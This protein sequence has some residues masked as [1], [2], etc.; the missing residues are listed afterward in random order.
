MANENEIGSTI[1]GAYVQ[2]RA[3]EPDDLEFLAMLTNDRTVSGMVVGWDFPVS[4]HGQT[5]WLEHASSDPRNKRLMVVGPGGERIGMTGLWDIDW[6]ARHA[7]GAIKLHPPA[8]TQKGIGTDAI[9]TLSAWAFYDVGM[10]KIQGSILD[11]NGPSLG[12]YA[13]KCGWK[14]EGVF[15]RHV[16]RK[17]EYHDAYWV[18]ILKE[19]FDALPDAAEYIDR[20][21]PVD[22]ETKV[23]AL[24]EWF[25]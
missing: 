21:V 23:D 7:I 25:A 17:G 11:F 15:R 8:L 18:S 14:I 24:P 1:R 6:Q 9:K 22:A 12:A 16:Y 13:K 5:R 10:Q 20:V 4:V 3:I 2:L 19:E